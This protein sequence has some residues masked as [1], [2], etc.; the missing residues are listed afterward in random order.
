MKRRQI[1]VLALIAAVSLWAACHRNEPATDT[2]TPVA[3]VTSVDT[4]PTGGTIL[5]ERT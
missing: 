5:S 4:T 3:T 1:E 2:G